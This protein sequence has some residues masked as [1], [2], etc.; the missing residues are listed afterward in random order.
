MYRSLYNLWHLLFAENIREMTVN[1]YD[2]LVSYHVSALFTNG[3]PDET[4]EILAVK[5]FTDNCFSKTHDY[6]D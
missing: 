6:I 4:I 1:E 2:I 5:A 3:C